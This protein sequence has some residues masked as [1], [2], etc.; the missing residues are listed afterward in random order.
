MGVTTISAR[1][2]IAIVVVLFLSPLGCVTPTATGAANAPQQAEQPAEAEEASADAQAEAQQPEA[3]DATSAD[4]GIE[5]GMTPADVTAEWSDYTLEPDEQTTTVCPTCSSVI[6]GQEVRS[7]DTLVG[8]SFCPCSGNVAESCLFAAWRVYRGDDAAQ[9]L[10]DSRGDAALVYPVETPGDLWQSDATNVS[11][12]LPFPSVAV[13]V[14]AAADDV[15]E[16]MPAPDDAADAV[17][18]ERSAL[19][20]ATRVATLQTPEGRDAAIASELPKAKRAGARVRR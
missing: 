14:F 9:F 1:L 10:S 15:C 4:L 5:W 6:A 16:G 19:W 13:S 11:L 3:R 8:F 17:K 2:G 7:R 18:T 20:I 12:A